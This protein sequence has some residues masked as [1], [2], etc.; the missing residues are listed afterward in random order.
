MQICG[1]QKEKCGMECVENYCGTVSNM[2]NAESCRV[3]GLMCFHTGRRVQGW[4]W[5]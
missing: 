4:W 2:Q 5:G 1:M 3:G